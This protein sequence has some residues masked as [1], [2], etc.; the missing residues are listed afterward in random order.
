MNKL[1]IIPTLESAEHLEADLLLLARLKPLH[2]YV[3]KFS[4]SNEFNSKQRDG[5]VLSALLDI[6][7]EKEIIDN[8]K[9]IGLNSS[10]EL[11]NKVKKNIEAK[12]QVKNQ[13]HKKKRHH[14]NSS[15]KSTGRKRKMK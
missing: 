7:S 10:G 15:Q 14:Q 1:Q 2:K 9:N 3:S 13:I 8:R 5:Y 11:K 4:K 6:V 12:T